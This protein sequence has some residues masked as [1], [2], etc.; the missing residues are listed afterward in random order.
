MKDSQIEL[1]TL[2]PV[3]PPTNAE[4]LADLAALRTMAAYLR[5]ELLRLESDLFW[6]IAM[7]PEAIDHEI[8]CGCKA[9]AEN[10]RRAFLMSR[11]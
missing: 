4:R 1:T 3:T 10:S 6:S 5:E 9:S 8:A 11:T 7:L 2:I